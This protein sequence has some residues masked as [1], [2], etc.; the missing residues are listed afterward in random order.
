MQITLTFSSWEEHDAYVASQAN[1][2]ATHHTFEAPTATVP[3]TRSLHRRSWSQYEMDQV[4]HYWPTKS[5][6]WIASALNRT[7]AAVQ[8]LVNTLRKAGADIALKRR[9]NGKVREE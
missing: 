7:P 2:Q 5:T 4:I 6:K 9:R 8:Q 3:V 1:R